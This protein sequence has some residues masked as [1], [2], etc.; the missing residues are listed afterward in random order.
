[1]S[2]PFDLERGP[3]LRAAVVRCGD[4]EG[5]DAA[6]P[7]HILLL[8]VHHIVFDGWSI[9]LLFNEISALY[10][11]H[12]EGRPGP[13]PALEIQY[14][15]FASWQ[16]KWLSPGNQAFESHL[17]YWRRQLCALPAL[18]FASDR[19]RPAIPSRRGARH[20]FRLSA[21]VTNELRAIGNHEACTPF[22]TLL[23]TFYA[24]MHRLTGQSD[25]VV[26]TD[27]ANRSRHEIENLIGF[28]V[29]QL[30]LR[31]DLSGDPSFR[32][33]LRRT[34]E[35]VLGAEEHQDLP[36][37][38]LVEALRPEREV[39]RSPLFQVKL[40]FADAPLPS[41][42]LPGMNM[43]LMEIE[44][45]L[46]QLD[47]ILFLEDSPE[48]VRASF[49]YSTDLFEASTMISLAD[50]YEA[51]IAQIVAAPE[52]PISTLLMRTKTMETQEAIPTR[53]QRTGIDLEKLKGIRPKPIHEA[54]MFH[55]AS[56]QLGEK[57]PI[58]LS[59][60]REDADLLNLSSQH[61][62]LFRHKLLEHGAILFRGFDTGSIAAFEAFTSSICADMF[63]ENG[64][65]PRESVAGNIATPVFFPP[66]RKLLWHNEN[67]FNY[68]WPQKIWFCC[69]KPADKG[70]ETPLVDSR[71]VYEQ[72]PAEVRE[73]FMRHGVKYV[74]NYGEGPGRS[75]Q[76]I[77]RTNDPRVVEEQCRKNLI[78]FEW[79][80]GDR[81]RTSSTRPA[82]VRHPIT[83][84][85]SWINQAQHWH[86]SCLDSA[87]RE[88][89]FTVFAEE[90]LP[91]NCFYGDGSP[92]ADADMQAVC[93]V[94]SKFEVH[95]PWQVGDILMVD[96]I[97]TA[98]ARN[99][100]AGTRKLLV[101]MGDLTSYAEVTA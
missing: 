46:T 48:G 72:M 58:V 75:W 68:R 88:S 91:R 63:L 37:D 56:L 82:A 95:F 96:N 78:G 30:V 83:G 51:L 22:V 9:K 80:D 92:I 52:I 85:Y 25:I 97:L 74:R 99:P 20:N 76:E 13:L 77:F 79:K 101:A 60:S 70:G 12:L 26:G 4:A 98:H 49:E 38:K 61:K 31:T 34:R 87:T 71:K 27:V 39:N 81:L 18:N 21:S 7:S 86:L 17:E 57:L 40:V 10:Q 43:S 23:A 90:D 32:T 67:T 47:L 19:A 64:E 73:R 50:S 29:N 5:D 89:L 53:R 94:Y 93:D 11:A 62:E 42:Q 59:P 6:Y 14:S 3:L 1:V 54:E 36:F 69:V 15:D 33:L 55:V 8:T 24:L 100:F 2:R 65:H 44:T 66:E 28:F 16:R 41:M 84:E 35:V 45:G